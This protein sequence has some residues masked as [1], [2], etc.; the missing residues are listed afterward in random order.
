L[1]AGKSWDGFQV[2]KPFARARVGIATPIFVPQDATDDVLEA[3]REELQQAL[4][5][6]SRDGDEWRAGLRK[7]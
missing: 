5:R 4:D 6:L 1:E 7:N 2:P 3:K